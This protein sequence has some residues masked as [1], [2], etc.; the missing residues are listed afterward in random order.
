MTGNDRP[1]LRSVVR[2]GLLAGWAITG[3]LID[4]GRATAQTVR[5][6]LDG[7]V[8]EGRP[9]AWSTKKVSMMLRDGSF[10]EFPP[11]DARQFSVVSQDFRPYSAG[12]MRATLLK[13]FS[14]EYDVTGTGQY[15]VVHPR[16]QREVWSGRFEQL[17]RSMLGYFRS[18]GYT[19]ERPQF[20]L[21]AVVFPTQQEFINYAAQ[22]DLAGVGPYTLGLYHELTNR[23]YLYDVTAGQPDSVSWYVNAET[24]IHEAAHQTAFNLQ[25][26][27]RLANTPSWV[28]EGV[29]TMF[30]A[31][32]VWDSQA[33]P[34]QVDRVNA[35]Q[36]ELAR[37][38]LSRDDSVSSLQQL[39]TDDMLFKADFERAYSLAWALTFYLAEKEPQ[40]YTRYLR[41][42]SQLNP[43]EEYTPED[44]LRDFAHHFGRDMKLLD[45]RL[46]RFITTLPDSSRR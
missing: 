26:H 4:P 30:E 16:D 14:A 37:T 6:A 43:G 8:Y 10:L 25:I 40:S 39:L 36:L 44:R 35:R 3:W 33:Y 2:V 38:Y 9:V 28:I 17:Y 31:R 12:E 24:I 19:V 32:G 18:R 11:D 27:K 21:V 42:L 29:G 41:Q 22:H 46:K 45:A 23:I 20:P 13:E 1:M 5:L 15:L 7:S 34:N